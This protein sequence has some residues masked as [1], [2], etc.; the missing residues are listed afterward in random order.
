[1]KPYKLLLYAAAGIIAGLLIENKAL[2]IKQSVNMKARRLKRQ[3]DKL[4]AKHQ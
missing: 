1:M 3:A 2:L 4:V